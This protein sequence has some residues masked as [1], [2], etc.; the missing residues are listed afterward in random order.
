VGFYADQ[1][2]DTATLGFL[3]NQRPAEKPQMD[4]NSVALM[5]LL[6][7]SQLGRGATPS[8]GRGEA[9]RLAQQELGQDL[10]SLAKVPRSRLPAVS[11]GAVDPLTGETVAGRSY[12]GFCAERDAA[13]KMGGNPARLRFTKPVRPRTGEVIPV[14]KEC[15]KVFVPEQFPPGTPFQ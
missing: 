6:P 2:N 10:A 3:A 13:A 11:V 1:F 8:L 12:M 14:C 9:L 4:F 5:L 15:Q 7:E